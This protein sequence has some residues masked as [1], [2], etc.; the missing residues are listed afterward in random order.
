MLPFLP[1]CLQEGEGA[2]RGPAPL[3]DVSTTA[4]QPPAADMADSVPASEFSMGNRPP[5]SLPSEAWVGEAG[6]RPPPVEVKREFDQFNGAA[7][8]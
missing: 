7:A 8:R 4:L 6:G 3:F 2:A 1:P 5:Q